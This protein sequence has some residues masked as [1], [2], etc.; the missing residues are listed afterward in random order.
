MR[1]VCWALI[2]CILCG[3]PMAKAQSLSGLARIDGS[4]S[5]VQDHNWQQVEIHLTMSQSVPYRIYQL[6]NPMRLIVEFNE[7]I[8]DS[9]NGDIF[10][11]SK[12]VSNVEFG[13]LGNGWSRL[14]MELTEPLGV[15]TAEMIYDKQAGN[16]VLTI[17]SGPV[18]EQEFVQ[19][20]GVPMA[21]GV[22]QPFKNVLFV[23]DQDKVAQILIVIDPGHGG[24][25]PGA[26]AGGVREADLMLLMALKLKDA[27]LRTQGIDVVL[28]RADD[29][30]PSLAERLRFSNRNKADVFV[31]LHADAVTKG[32]ARGTT[33]YTLSEQASDQT[34]AQLAQEHDRA[35]LLVGLDL[36]GAED[37]IADVLIDLA[38]QD[39]IP[40]SE[41]LAQTTIQELFE[42]IGSVNTKPLR[43][44]NFS[45]LKSPDVPSILIEVG[46][47]STQSD[48]ENLLDETW[49][50]NFVQGVRNGII[51]WVGEDSI[52]APLRRQ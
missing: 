31:S 14:V 19:A 24:A 12:R 23:K 2:T 13:A 39:N 30:Y 22:K 36:S 41:A 5:Y 11:Q 52:V 26:V 44:A 8:F 49:R 10:D 42:V 7:V 51:K 33:I 47:M 35:E 3:A 38:R 6:D 29:T 18:T 40:R 20:S 28:T 50:E 37:S 46:F 43:H 48:L 45:V 9:L 4:R 21:S 34:S 15:K 16:S 27:L 25:D 32:V 1:Q 17:W